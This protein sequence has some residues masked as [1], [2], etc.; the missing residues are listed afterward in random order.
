MNPKVFGIVALFAFFVISPAQADTTINTISP[1]GPGLW[2]APFGAPN[3]ATYGEVFTVTGPDTQLTSFSLYLIDVPGSGCLCGSLLFNAYIGS[4]DGSKVSNILYT[5]PTLSM[6]AHS[7]GNYIP[8]SFNPNLQLSIGQYVAFL[9][10][11]NQPPQTSLDFEMPIGKS[12]PGTE[13]VFFNN[14]LDFSALTTQDWDC[15]DCSSSVWFN[16]NLT[17]TSPV[18]DVPL[19]AALPLFATG[20]GALGLLGW[21]RK[22]KIQRSPA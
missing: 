5:S 1:P 2:A 21:R 18:S 14:G 10:I 3:T 4:W 15:S 22:R 12:V 20:L 13:F 6:T 17:S 19:P 8:F 7:T 11:S 16:A 9:S